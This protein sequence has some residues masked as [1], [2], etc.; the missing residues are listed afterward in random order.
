M[1]VLWKY[2]HGFMIPIQEI[3]S[4][5]TQEWAFKL[6]VYVFN[7]L[8]LLIISN[9]ILLHHSYLSKNKTEYNCYF[10]PKEKYK[11]FVLELNDFGKNL[12]SNFISTKIKIRF[13]FTSGFQC[14]HDLS[15]RGLVITGFYCYWCVELVFWSYA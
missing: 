4:M 3:A 11:E 14:F 6:T 7:N 1:A 12:N 5:K 10:K 13:V 9:A 2:H 8:L 15:W